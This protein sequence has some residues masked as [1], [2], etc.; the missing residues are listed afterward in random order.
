MRVFYAP[1][2]EGFFDDSC[3]SS[4]LSM[5]SAIVEELVKRRADVVFHFR[6]HPL[7]GTTDPRY[8]VAVDKL[9]SVAREHGI[10]GS[11][12]DANRSLYDL[13]EETDVLITDVSSVIS[14]FLYVERPVIVCNALA[15]ADMSA[16]FPA[17]AGCYILEREPFALGAILD[18]IRNG[19]PRR[20]ER[21]ATRTSIFGVRRGDSLA[22][23][24]RGIDGMF[25][26]ATLERDRA[27]KPLPP[28][29]A[30]PAMAVQMNEIIT[31]VLLEAETPAGNGD[32]LSSPALARAIDRAETDDADAESASEDDD[33]DANSEW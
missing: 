28:E 2:W 23:F 22:A 16:Q 21:A 6:P 5:G 14:D 25:E 4:V 26:V 12:L 10:A 13:F 33:S 32:R 3:Y 19:D 29:L 7:T 20:V 15:V 8:R 30:V 17:A 9:A 1:T 11:V 31:R 18:A 24:K 27:R